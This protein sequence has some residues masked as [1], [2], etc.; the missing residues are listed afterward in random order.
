M[1]ELHDT[2]FSILVVY[3]N[4]GG[5]FVL[6]SGRTCPHDFRFFTGFFSVAGVDAESTG[7]A[8]RSPGVDGFDEAS[9]DAVVPEM[10][11][12]TSCFDS[13]GREGG[14]ITAV[15]SVVGA[16]EACVENKEG[17]ISPGADRSDSAGDGSNLTT[18][19]PCSSQAVI[20][21][22]VTASPGICPDF[23]R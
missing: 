8:N 7:V 10:K 23:F 9:A 4:L 21:V 12:A 1:S 3:A 16:E 13:A 6:G 22:N 5:R 17:Y 19:E 18:G 14:V 2:L 15:G 11:R 20:F